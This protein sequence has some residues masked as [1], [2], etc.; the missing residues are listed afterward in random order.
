MDLANLEARID[1]LLAKQ[2]GRNDEVNVAYE[3]LEGALSL[4]GSIY[5]SDSNQ[6]VSLKE[7]A[8]AVQTRKE[9]AFWNNVGDIERAAKG[10]LSNLKAELKAGLATSLQ[11]KLEGGV[12]TDFIQLA[13]SV[14][15]E[16]G[17]NPKKLQPFLPQLL[18]KIPFG[19]W[20]KVSVIRQ[21]AGI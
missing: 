10:A 11:R 19:E 15:S 20:P 18:T 9:R 14:L 1:E 6:V 21:P 17:E 16:Q 5:G 2:A 12:L 8:K 13:R 7:L 3:V 4:L